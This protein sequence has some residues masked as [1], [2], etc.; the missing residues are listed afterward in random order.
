MSQHGHSF[1]GAEEWQNPR[2]TGVNTLPGHATSVSYPDE[3]L[4]RNSDRQRSPRFLSLNGTWR[5]FFANNPASAP[6]IAD[7]NL[8]DSSWGLIAVPGNWELQGWGIA[9]YTNIIYP[10][11]PV[12]PPFVPADDNP[13]GCY[14]TTFQLPADWQDQQITLHFGGVSSAFYCWL[15]GRY[16][17]FGKGSRVPA[18]FDITPHLE[19][20]ENVLAVKVLRWSDG[21][22]LE[23]QDHWRLSGIH[24]DVY[25]A[26]APKFQL[27]DFFVQTDL[28]AQYHDARLK[29]RATVRNFGNTVPDGWILE[30]RLYNAQGEAV[31]PQPMSVEVEKLL[32][33]DWM[34]RGNVPFADLEAHVANPLKWSAEFPHLYT[35][36]LTLK[37][38]AGNSVDS[39]SCQ[40]GF[41]QVEIRNRQLHLNGRSIKLYGVNRHD[42]HHIL[43]TTVTEESMLRDVR[44]LKQFN[45]N[46][47]RASHYPNNPRW[48]ELC[49]EYGLYLIDETDLETHGIGAQL[50]NDPA[51]TAAFIERAQ[52][53]VERDKN[54]PCV[55]CWSLGNESG[56][57]PNHA[58]MS[59]WIK[60]Y[61]RTRFVHYEGAQGNTSATDM[62]V[63][64]D[65][66]YVD[67]V[68][69]MY[70]EI[71]TMIKWSNDPHETR[72]V[73]WCEYAH[74]MGN[75]LGNFYKYWDAIRSHDAL[76]GAFVWDWTDQGILQTAGNGKKF[77]AY[78][79][80][81]GDRINSGSFCLNGLIN[82]DQTPK[83]VA[84]EAKRVQQP[85]VIDAVVD[86][87]NKFRITNW[88]DF[89]DLSVY[90]LNWE[91]AENGRV[92]ERGSLPPL[93]TAPRC[94]DTITAPWSKPAFV[95]GAEYHVKIIFSLGHDQIWAQK[96]HV[97]AWA[98]FPVPVP[99][100]T[101]LCVDPTPIPPLVLHDTPA[102]IMVT[103]RDFS[104][105]WNKMSGLLQSYRLG[106]DEILRSPLRPN[107][108][109]PI[110]DN[111][112]GG[113][114]PARSGLWKDPLKDSIVKSARAVHANERVIKVTVALNLPHVQSEWTTTCTVH[115]SGEILV[116]NEFAADPGMPELPRIGMQVRIDGAYDR[117]Q[118]YGLGP[119]ETYWDRHRG[120]AVGCY[121]ASVK[122]DFFNYVRPQESNNHWQTRWASLTDERGCGLLIAGLTPLSFS[123]WPCGME[124]LE[125]SR[126]THELPDRDFI[127]LNIDHLQMGV[128]GDDSWSENARPHPEFRILPGRYRY[129][130]RIIPVAAG[131]DIDPPPCR[132]PT[133]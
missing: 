126:H 122:K 64:P 6:V 42:F 85:I 87:V 82:P 33:R 26:A 116:E 103:G 130:F 59:G 44:L 1:H 117:L 90:D 75:S 106:G 11:E 16:V 73:L 96:G 99:A 32:K 29:I 83:P 57:G 71:D 88:H 47:V 12:N 81:F 40:V 108:W 86:G 43:G 91:L 28:D 94:V 89:T 131:Q 51:W 124:D 39:R 20:G 35:L 53:L 121:T 63:R 112:V 98:Q 101:V 31:L 123:A 15:N 133:G 41:R 115:G 30:G 38:A 118:W 10:F 74:A 65:P 48:L 55:I 13:V 97:V 127:T 46:A 61:D 66:P 18:E 80:D 67:V 102:L 70:L 62:D 54:H 3:A 105:E 24:R 22:Y 5:F 36:T 27:Y 2:I 110:T 14:R 72:P 17:G 23:D 50:T 21:S 109:R 8:D 120:A 79:G 58:A 78:G 114:M 84:W 128:G 49:D 19:K 9:I 52:R 25:L 37:D 100:S 4:A 77:W 119:H 68:S 113:G 125:T 34:H 76:I 45:F 60:E 132:L 92:I 129:A 107:F 7:Q 95:P 111:D 69:R 93:R 56:S 104:L